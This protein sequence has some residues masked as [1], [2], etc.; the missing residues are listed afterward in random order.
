MHSIFPLLV[1]AARLA[2]ALA[3]AAPMAL[4]VA[5]Q[6]DLTKQVSA[7][8]EAIDDYRSGKEAKI[9]SDFV[10]LLAI[11]N[12]AVDLADME[13]NAEHIIGLLESRGFSARTL[14]E[15]GAP[16][17]YAELPTPGATETVLIYAHFDGQPVQEENWTYPPFSPTLLDGPLPDGKPVAIDKVNGSF[18]PEWR[19][20]GRSAGDDKMPVIALIHTLDALKAAG[21]DRSVNIKLFLDGEEEM[22]SPTVAEVIDKHGKLLQADVLLFCDGPMH[23]SRRT[24]IVF[25]VRGS[26]TVDITTYGAT[27]PLHSGHYGNWSPNPIMQMAYLLTSMRDESGRI[28]VK[29]YYDNVTPLSELEMEAI[30][31]M[32]DVTETLKDELSVNAPEGDGA[33]LEELI[34]LPA[35][36]MRGFVAGGVGKKGRNIV[37]ST[38]T[39]SIDL[40]LVPEQTP[41]S[42]RKLLEDHVRAQ[43]FHVVYEEP[44]AEI[45]RAHPKVAKMEWKDSGYPALRT[46][47]DDPMAK[48]LTG[49]MR[50][51]SPELIVTPTMGGSLPLHEFGSRLSAPIIILPLANH[52]NNQH[53]E[54]ENIRLQNLWDAMAIYGAVLAHFGEQDY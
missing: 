15:G 33:R 32:P 17:I 23:Q 49:L 29:G 37:L 8:R 20:Y 11:P 48:R 22:G 47:L 54:N 6:S 35:L 13:R 1:R 9:V 3:V 5:A 18:E 16:Y 19:L 44:S 24:Q 28:L 43:G 45:L 51:I 34:A 31:G 4:P 39:A 42:T 21:I 46:R 36:N 38:A 10:D 41:E 50:E 30:E 14:R 26:T 2:L 27:R 7:T 53:A 52:D 40:R 25:G 12:V